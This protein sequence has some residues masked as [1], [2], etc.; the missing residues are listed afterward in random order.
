MGK[1]SE[2]Q[3]HVASWS[4]GSSTYS[5]SC[6]LEAKEIARNGL[7]PGW[8]NC[9]LADCGLRRAGRAHSSLATVSTGVAS[10]SLLSPCS[11]NFLALIAEFF[12][13]QAR[14][15]PNFWATR[16][17]AFFV[18][19]VFLFFLGGG[20]GLHCKIVTSSPKPRLDKSGLKK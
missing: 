2:K 4:P 15:G 7:A 13:S 10:H 1:N 8:V 12:V 3:V 5:G 18:F 9:E 17:L 11:R 6:C 14:K 16:S 20:V 19:F